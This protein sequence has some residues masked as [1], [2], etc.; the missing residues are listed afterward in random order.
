MA[1]KLFKIARESRRRAR[2]RRVADARMIG[3]FRA[4]VLLVASTIAARR[5]KRAVGAI[6]H[7]R[8]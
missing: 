2:T 1:Y 5:R 7:S 8:K 6:L 3:H 4:R